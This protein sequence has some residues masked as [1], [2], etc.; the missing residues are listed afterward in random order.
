MIVGLCLVFSTLLVAMNLFIARSIQGGNEKIIQDNLTELASNG[1]IYARQF[2]IIGGKNNDSEGF[3]DIAQDTVS[4]L[5]SVTGNP[6]GAYSAE[7]SL[8]CATQEGVFRGAEYD[9]LSYAIRGRPAYTLDTVGQQTFAYFSYPVAVAGKNVGIIRTRVDYSVIYAQGSGLMRSVTVLTSIAFLAALLISILLIQGISSPLTKLASISGTIA[10]SIEQDALRLGGVETMLNTRRQD[11]VGKLSR[12]FSNMI[13]KIDQQMRVI[14]A[15]KQELQRLAEYRKEFYDTVTHEL[16]TP[17]TSIRGYAEVLEE[18]GFT[19]EEFFRKAVYHIKQE[20]SRMYGMVVALVELSKL[21]SSVNYPKEV[22]DLSALAA[23]VCDGMQFKAQKYGT[24]IRFS[25]ADGARVFASP[26]N[27]KEVLINL[28]DNAIKYK[29]PEGGIDLEV[30]LDRGAGVVR[31]TVTNRAN[32]IPDA[33]INRLFEPFYQARTNGY[34]EDGSSGLG[35]AIC[36][37]IVEVHA[38]RIR[39]ENL[40]DGLIAVEVTLPLYEGL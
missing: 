11:E 32:H 21:S 39:M 30:L 15:D 18:N 34:R 19:D 2:L 40:P 26:E 6:A 24:G 36:K 37:Q 16:K 9:D 29:L 38:G 1:Q 35:L 17:L 23:D 33:E 12:N 22:F 4:E 20:S 7:G 14:Q 25:G 28:L 10:R 3:S 31:A 8:L 13:R 27:L 5:A